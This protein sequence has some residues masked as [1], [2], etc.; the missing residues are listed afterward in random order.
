MTLTVF[1]LCRQ[2]VVRRHKRHL[3]GRLCSSVVEG[4]PCPNG[5]P[6]GSAG[7]SVPGQWRP[8]GDLDIQPMA[9]KQGHS[10]RHPPPLPLP[11][12]GG[13]A[14]LTPAPPAPR[15]VPTSTSPPWGT[16][17]AARGSI[18]PA[19]RPGRSHTTPNAAP[20]RGGQTDNRQ[21]VGTDGVCLLP[22]VGKALWPTHPR[23]GGQ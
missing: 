20:D 10:G 4:R 19:Q 21:P 3:Q 16:R 13:S 7:W 12:G 2:P 8:H 17:S 23:T 22:W 18:A 6:G 1:F 9:N 11:H 14:S 15:S 5:R